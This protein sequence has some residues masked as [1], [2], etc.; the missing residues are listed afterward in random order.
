SR[1]PG[2]GHE[3]R[4]L[5]DGRRI[6]RRK[7]A[8][9]EPAAGELLPDLAQPGL[10][11]VAQAEDAVLAV[12][13]AG[14]HRDPLDP[15]LDVVVHLLGAGVHVAVGG[16]RAGERGQLAAARVVLDVLEIELVELEEKQLRQGGNYA[17]RRAAIAPGRLVSGDPHKPESV[18]TR[19]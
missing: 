12:R 2:V 1:C 3:E 6:H 4:G 8:Y 11:A 14:V 7:G 16:E 10:S 5:R 13:L 15:G 18:C 19:S 9:P 17:T